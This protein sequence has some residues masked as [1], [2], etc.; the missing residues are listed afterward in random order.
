MKSDPIWVKVPV[1][2]GE[3]SEIDP[4]AEAQVGS[5]SRTNDT[6]AAV[7]ATPVS[8]PPTATPLSSTVDVYYEVT[9]V[10]GQFRPGQRLAVTL[11]LTGEAEQR[12]IPWSAIVQDIHGGSWVYEATA[13]HTFVRRRAQV[14]QVVNGWAVLDKGPAVG[15]KIVIEGVAEL[16]GTEFG[17]GK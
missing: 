10:D 9:N 14:R 16:F 6:P 11:A 7:S 5:L 2:V 8:A 1:Y 13:P 17:F 4:Q 15:A 3:L 12:G